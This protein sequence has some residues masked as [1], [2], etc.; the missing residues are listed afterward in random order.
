M[1]RYE[2]QVMTTCRSG[3]ATP[4]S[5][6]I[7]VCNSFHKRSVNCIRVFNFQISNQ[8]KQKMEIPAKRK[9]LNK[10][11]KSEEYFIFVGEE[12]GQ[13]YYEC[14]LCKKKINATKKS[15]LAS[16]I[17]YHP[18][19]YAE[20][21]GQNSTIENKRLKLL[22]DCVELV[23][24]NGRSFNCLKDSAIQSMNEELLKE[25]KAAGRELNLRDPHFP[26]V[27]D[28]L[29]KISKEIQG[30]IA[31]ELKNRAVSLLVDIVTKRHRSIL[32]ISVQYMINDTVK[33][34]SIGM[35]ELKEKHTGK[36]LADLII[37]RLKQLGVELKQVITITTD[38]G[39]NVLKMIRDVEQHLQAAINETKQ[40]STSSSQASA[41][42]EHQIET[43]TSIAVLTDEQAIDLILG[44]PE[45]D[46]DEP[47]EEELRSNENLLTEIQSNMANDF[48]FD[49]VWDVK[50]IKCIAHTLQLAINDSINATTQEIRNV[51]DLSRRICKH[52]RLISTMRTLKDNGIVYPTPRIDVVTRW[53]SLYLMVNIRIYFHTSFFKYT[54]NVGLSQ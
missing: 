3:N 27:K 20:I 1:M 28:E 40:S 12:S 44:Q 31:N 37:E 5:L 38:N 35:I 45:N 25:L 50:G 54:K 47:S 24:V 13:K 43:A 30:K 29:T 39:S 2:T 9:R 4:L 7:S 34:R 16:H 23:S 41:A 26:E 51:I 10:T 42:N 36:Y 11:E 52:L 21:C 33:V 14:K 53:G 46:D 19:I 32:G 17:R 18:E 22:L 49:A 48:G 15:N 8:S 6:S